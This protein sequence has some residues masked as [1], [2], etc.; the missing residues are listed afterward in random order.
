MSF[1]D[2]RAVRDWCRQKFVSSVLYEQNG[3]KPIFNLV[4]VSYGG[5]V[6]VNPEEG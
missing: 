1:L 3:V 5:Q 2:P 4:G 6:T